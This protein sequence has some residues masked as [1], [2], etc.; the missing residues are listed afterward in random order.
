MGYSIIDQSSLVNY[1]FYPRKEY[2]EPPQGAY[3]LMVPVE[4]GVEVHCRFHMGAEQ[5]PWLIYFHG[6]GEVVSD[7]DF[8]APY[9]LAEGINL[10]AADYRGYGKSSGSPSIGA[11]LS[12]A[13]KILDE[14]KE[15]LSRRNLDRDKLWVMG[16]SLGSICALEL[17]EKRPDDL[18]GLIVESGFISVVKLISHLGLPSPGDLTPL[19]KESHRKVS[20]ITL[21]ALV[22][23]GERDRL[24]PL[25]QGE[26][27]YQTLASEKK[28]FFTIPLADHNNIF[29]VERENYLKEIR[30]LVRGE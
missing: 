30:K 28:K 29:F 9:Y 24:V 13:P 7:L 8:L 26:E 4:Q 27:I 15:E 14:I 19:E 6:N 23:H 12:D 10:V 1:L 5:D 11:I 25:E 21:P 17:A 18:Q 20:N 2:S 16:R 22:I 3:D